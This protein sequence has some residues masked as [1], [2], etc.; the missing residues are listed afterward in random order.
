MITGLAVAGF[1]AVYHLGMQNFGL[2]RIYDARHGNPPEMGRR[3]DYWM[4]Q[5]LNLGPFVAGLSLMPTAQAFRA[6]EQLGWATPESWLRAL[7]PLQGSFAPYV[8]SAGLLYLLFYLCSYVRLTRRGYRPCAQKIA[9]LVSSGAVSVIAWG[10]L[11]PWKAF[12]VMNFFHGLQY[13]AI[14][15]WTERQTLRRILRLDRIR[16]GHWLALLAFAA[17]TLL[18]GIGYRLYGLDPVA[19]RW[20]AALALSISLLH[21]WYDGFVWSVRKQEV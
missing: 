20:A 7:R 16:A 11:T 21:Y 6:F 10:F 1:W 8:L 5:V 15:W 19:L 13:F 9:L 14:V 4:T 2:C 18:V 17:A 12:F 3:L